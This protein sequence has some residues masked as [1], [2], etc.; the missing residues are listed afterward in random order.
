MQVPV[1]DLKVQEDSQGDFLLSG[2]GRLK[3]FSLFFVVIRGI[4]RSL[5]F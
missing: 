4:K 2:T 5:F 3:V 1:L